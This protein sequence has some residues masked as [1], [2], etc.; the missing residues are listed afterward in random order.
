MKKIL[1]IVIILII[2]FSAFYVYKK[3]YLKDGNSSLFGSSSSNKIFDNIQLNLTDDGVTSGF[4]IT[5][6]WE[7]NVKYDAQSSYAK[8][9][10]AVSK[11]DNGAGR[12]V[13]LT[14]KLDGLTL[15]GSKKG[16]I[17]CYIPRSEITKSQPYLWAKL[18]LYVN[19]KLQKPTIKSFGK[20]EN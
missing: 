1:T 16:R 10:L 3:Y 13:I 14:K 12:R 20:F 15:D 7:C 4:T 8:I 19:G 5:A 6:S 2:A 9:E 11:R 18:S 17:N